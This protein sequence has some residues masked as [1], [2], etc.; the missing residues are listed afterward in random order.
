MNVCE[1]TV[2]LEYALGTSH[3]KNVSLSSA[4]PKVEV[5]VAVNEKLAEVSVVLAEGEEVIVVSG[6]VISGAGAVIVQV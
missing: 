5:S 4:H 6:G 1:P 2:K 3:T